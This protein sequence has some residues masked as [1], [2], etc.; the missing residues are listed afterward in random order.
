M[1]IFFVKKIRYKNTKTKM[2]KLL[3]NKLEFNSKK[4]NKFKIKARA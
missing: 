1:V 4:E 3:G 2:I